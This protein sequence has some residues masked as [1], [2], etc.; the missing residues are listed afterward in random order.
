M[1]RVPARARL[2]DI[3]M[4]GKRVWAVKAEIVGEVNLERGVAV[5][6]GADFFAVEIDGGI[7]VDAVELNGNVLMLR[8]RL[9]LSSSLVYIRLLT[10]SL[11][12]DDIT[13]T[14]IVL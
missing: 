5:R 1:R 11:L 14:K 13:P 2:F 10:G 8:L 6:M 12:I 9:I 3:G 7:H 4:D